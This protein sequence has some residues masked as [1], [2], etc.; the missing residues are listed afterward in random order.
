ME[1]RDGGIEIPLEPLG[2][3]R[4]VFIIGLNAALGGLAWLVVLAR[5]WT[6]IRILRTAALDDLLIVIGAVSISQSPCF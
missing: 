5:L 2:H 3:G 4:V 6:R 1:P